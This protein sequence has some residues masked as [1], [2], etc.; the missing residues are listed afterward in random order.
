MEKRK[1]DALEAALGRCEVHGHRGHVESDR[2]SFSKKF[3]RKSKTA[4]RLFRIAENPL[5]QPQNMIK[6][7]QNLSR[8]RDG[9]NG[10]K[11]EGRRL[12][13]DAGKR[14]E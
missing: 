13:P 8:K 3:G 14:E 1:I 9:V 12:P 10:C 2:N 5:H 7:H 6:F 11:E 4:G